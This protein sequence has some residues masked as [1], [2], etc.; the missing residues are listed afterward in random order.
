GRQSVPGS[1]SLAADRRRL[2]GIAGT[3]PRSPKRNLYLAPS[4]ES[5]EKCLC[6]SQDGGV[7]PF[8]EQ[9]VGLGQCLSGLGRLAL[10]VQE[11]AQAYDGRQLEHPGALPA[12][13]GAGLAETG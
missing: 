8:R 5:F 12:G 11:A 9:L 4:R 10:L 2:C 3:D 7:E 6:F 1:N 13:R